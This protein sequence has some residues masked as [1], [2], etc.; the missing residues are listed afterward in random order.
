MKLLDIY[1]YKGII[2]IHLAGRYLKCQRIALA[3]NGSY[4]FRKRS[5]SKNTL[6]VHA[7]LSELGW[8]SGSS[9]GCC[10]EITL[11]E[12]DGE[13]HATYR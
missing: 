2:T 5:F 8:Y 7:T 13:L 4:A 6:V 12:E 1:I 10:K 3:K 9:K 11:E